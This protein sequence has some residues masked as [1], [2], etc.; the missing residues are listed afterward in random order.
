MKKLVLSLAMGASVLALGACSFDKDARS[1]YFNV[2]YTM[3]RTAGGPKAQAEPVA[4]AAE[5]TYAPA[6]QQGG[7]EA[8]SHATRK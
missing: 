6:P 8:V 4:V 5:E 1:T 2:P 7:E 3:E